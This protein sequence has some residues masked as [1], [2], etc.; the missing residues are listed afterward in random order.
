M[1]IWSAMIIPIITAVVLYFW[2]QH[3]T[4][5][6][7]FLIPFTA[8][9]ILILVCKIGTELSQTNDTEYWGGWMTTAEH[10]EAWDEEVPCRH[11]K[12]ETRTR[13]RDGKTETYQEFVGYEHTY[14]VDYH[15]EYYEATDSND[16]TEGI[17]RSVFDSIVQKFGNSKK[18]DLHRHYHSIDG[19]KFVSTWPGSDITLI[20]F[21]SVHTYE[22][23][24][25]TT[26]TILDFKE[27]DPKEYGLFD[28][29]AITGYYQ[30]PSILGD[31]GETMAEAEKLLSLTNAK[32]GRSKQIRLWI[33]IFKDQPLDAG[34]DQRDYWKGG[35][36]NEFTLTIGVNAAHE[37]QWCYPISWT[38][39]DILKVD[40]RNFVIE[41]KGKKLNLVS[42]V[43]WLTK[44]CDERFIRKEFVDFAFLTV[45][46][47]LWGYIL[48]FVLTTL[49]NIGLSWFI[50]V[51][52]F[53]EESGER[54]FRFPHRRKIFE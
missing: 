25:Q 1:M 4:L 29:P 28:Y 21:T 43:N 46:P 51:N 41:Q 19:D 52:E 11:P 50:V 27:V 13:V 22:N 31:G 45:D 53:E 40:A 23:R 32:L 48:T 39:V 6:W 54:K 5:W 7:E 10:Y 15:P 33:L 16:I 49:M 9:A 18:V 3:K 44:E 42:I 35:N 12:Y 26:H 47:P 17:D 38:E 24:V 34:F 36:K 2:F 37:V 8:S 14:D 30:C 20:P